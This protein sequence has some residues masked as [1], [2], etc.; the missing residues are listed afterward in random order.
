MQSA[1]DNSKTKKQKRS[2]FKI[3]KP[4]PAI[5]QTS[6]EKPKRFIRWKVALP[7]FS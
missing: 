7:Y 4:S 2:W 6:L 5:D 1:E 3:V